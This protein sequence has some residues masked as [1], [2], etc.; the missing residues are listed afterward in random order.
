M[1]EIV[2]KEIKLEPVIKGEYLTL[3]CNGHTIL[4]DYICPYSGYIK[5]INI[6]EY[7]NEF[8]LGSG[9]IGLIGAKIQLTYER[10]Q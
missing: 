8:G 7:E 5:V 2:S 4:D 10:R 6:Y 9:F 3:T 1:L